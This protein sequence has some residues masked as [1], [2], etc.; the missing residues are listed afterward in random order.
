MKRGLERAYASR[1]HSANRNVYVSLCVEGT[2]N[3]RESM[4]EF[5]VR[6]GTPDGQIVER[7]IQA[8]NVNAAEDDLRRQGMH[9]FAAKRGSRA[10]RDLLPRSRKVVTMERF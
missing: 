4:P 5:I 1:E 7:H 8:T 9:V 2:D 6:V 3:A 10:I